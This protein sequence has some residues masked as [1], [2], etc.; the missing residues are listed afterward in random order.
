M[1][2]LLQRELNKKNCFDLPEQEV[3]LSLL[4]TTSLLENVAERF[5]R[6]Y[7]L[8]IA[9]FNVLRIL[10]AAGKDGKTCSQIGED[11]VARV[12]DVTRL[13][14]RLEEAGLV[15]RS[16]ERDDRRVVRVTLMPQ[17]LEVVDKLNGP[18]LE[19]HRLQLGHLTKSEL[20]ELTR[21]LERAREPQ[22]A[23]DAK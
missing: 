16:R 11:M 17:G 5:F 18:V 9:T 14:D 13:V 19:L 15:K 12:P 3:F 21:L 7:G 8:S 22:I 1:A 20:S 4:R 6:E 10:R 23:N 2:G